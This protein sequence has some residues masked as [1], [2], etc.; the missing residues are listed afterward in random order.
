MRKN[1]FKNSKLFL[2]IFTL[3]F[4]IF[5]VVGLSIAAAPTVPYGMATNDDFPKVI[6]DWYNENLVS[7]IT[8][9][10]FDTPIFD[11]DRHG[12]HYSGVVNP[13]MTSHEEMMDFI[14]NL[15]TTYMRWDIVGNITTYDIKSANF[16]PLKNF[17]I[18]LVVFSNPPRFDAAELRALGKPIYYIQGSIH[19]NEP[20][21]AEATLEIMK[22]LSKD[23]F[24]VLDKISVVVLP[25]YNIDGTYFFQRG[26]NSARGITNMDQNRDHGMFASPMTRIVETILNS[27]RPEMGTDIHEMGWGTDRGNE[28][29]YASGVYGSGDITNY[30]PMTLVN[31][32]PGATEKKM[33]QT[34]KYYQYSLWNPIDL[35]NRFW[36]QPKAFPMWQDKLLEYVTAGL[37]SK[38]IYNF[39]YLMN[40]RTAWRE[41][42]VDVVSGDT[43]T[44]YPG[45]IEEPF[46]AADCIPDEGYGD[47]A[48]GLKGMVEFCAEVPSSKIGG[49]GFKARMYSHYSA[50]EYEMKFLAENADAVLK[51][52][53]AARKSME[54]DRSPIALWSIQS[55]EKRELKVLEMNASRDEVIGIRE[56]TIPYFYSNKNNKAGKT[57]RRP[58]A[59]IIDGAAEADGQKINADLAVFRLAYT[60]IPVMRL[61]EP[62]TIEVEGST[63]NTIQS[64]DI[65]NTFK[66][67]DFTP[68]LDNAGNLKNG[69]LPNVTTGENYLG[70]YDTAG[71]S[72]G[73]QRMSIA[74]ATTATETKTFPAGTY[75]IPMDHMS[76]LHASL[77]LEVLGKRNMG[78]S[79][80]RFRPQDEYV[81]TE[82][83]YP[84][85]YSQNYFPIEEGKKFPAYRYMGA[86]WKE[87]MKLERVYTE[88]PLLKNANFAAG[89]PINMSIL[90]EN[91]IDTSKISSINMGYFFKAEGITT[92]AA[93]PLPKQFEVLIPTK[94]ENTTL[95]AWYLYNWKEKTFVKASSSASP[96]SGTKTIPVSEKFVDETGRV[97]LVSSVT[98]EAE[99]SGSSGCNAGFGIFALFGLASI[100]YLNRK[101]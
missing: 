53:V 78:T 42:S 93:H 49:D 101:K 27:Y 84:H 9:V 68:L 66:Y 33:K 96:S 95:D 80:W 57:V 15:P 87:E 34:Q 82:Y 76:N 17:E 79:Y 98:G 86:N 51:D 16:A 59:Y 52:I 26:T 31:T 62:A 6:Y 94:H 77:L 1:F 48:L 8:D 85:Q 81:K 14:K 75:V 44:T 90:K 28:R 29:Y 91:K 54:T 36:N 60:G 71:S 11:S 25:R 55:P 4:S 20:S 65:G 58:Y 61:T 64:M 40:A 50:M 56:H 5:A 41:V 24:K 12:N 35:G 88:Q 92:E 13:T 97:L 73:I 72:F 83:Q 99:S 74:K 7:K 46:I 32:A 3:V 10:K 43:L 30:V 39:P 69:P 100:P 47:G 19:A 63:V 89:Y 21:G 2:A 67:P 18:P 22:K 45:E 38:G 70:G 37:E 23:E